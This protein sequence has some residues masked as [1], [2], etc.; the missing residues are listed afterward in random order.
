MKLVSNA[1]PLIFLAKIDLIELLQHC[2]H[3]TLVPPAVVAEVG[4]DLPGFIEQRPLSDLGVAYVNGAIGSLHRGELEAMMLAREQK[5]D[6]VAM[7]DRSARRRAG[8]MGL[9]PI[10]TLGLL[11]LFQQ[12]GLLQTVIAIE[13]LDRLVDQHGLYLSERLHEEARQTLAAP[14]NCRQ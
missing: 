1:S 10:G 12:R 2:F 6:Q 4:S 11:V 9:Q 7:D 3:Q 13:K 14:P 8:A 5:I